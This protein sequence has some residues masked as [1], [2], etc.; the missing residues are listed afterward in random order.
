MGQLL[1]ER[2]NW[3]PVNCAQFSLLL[4]PSTWVT[5]WRV[6]RTGNV[7]QCP[8]HTLNTGWWCLQHHR[9]C[10]AWGGGFTHTKTS[11]EGTRPRTPLNIHSCTQRTPRS[12]AQP[13]PLSCH[14]PGRRNCI[15]LREPPWGLLRQAPTP[16][17]SPH[18][19]FGTSARHTAAAR[20]GTSLPGFCGWEL[21]KGVGLHPPSCS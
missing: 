8:K 1:R 3:N 12:P 18:P 15:A 6:H 20:V 17:P 16:L 13:S 11:T 5:G 9:S 10:R 4:R 21:G 19:G 7:P 14:P 2:F